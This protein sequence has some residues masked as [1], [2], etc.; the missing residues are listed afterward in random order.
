V[1]ESGTATPELHVETKDHIRVVT[2]DRPDRRNALNAAVRQGIIEAFQSAAAEDD[3]RVLVIT[4]TGD[5]AFCAGAD[6]KEISEKDRTGVFRGPMNQPG[7][8]VMEVIAETYKPTIAALNG[9]AVGG[10]CEIALAC[11]ILIAA[12]GVHLALP[13][14][15]L[16]MGAVFGSVALPRRIPLGI[17]LEHLFTGDP[18][19]AQEAQRWGLVNHIVPRERLM[20]ETM[21]LAR[22]IAENAPLTVR[23]MKEMALKGLALPLSSAI[24]LDVG[25]D[26]YT[27]EDRKEGIA[28]FLEKRKPNWKGR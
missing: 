10:G 7:R 17:A 4:G 5:K 6:L 23:R 20:D 12:E 24:R 13:E 27:S 28:A 11:D 14:A 16:G 22:R 8:L 9:H 19:P 1:T 25:P 2:I 15:K 3:V 26:P 21:A 18:L